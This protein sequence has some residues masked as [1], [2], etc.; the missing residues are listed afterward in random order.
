MCENPFKVHLPIMCNGHGHGQM[1][2]FMRDMV[3]IKRVRRPR[4]GDTRR[5][6][7]WAW[8]WGFRD[9]GTNKT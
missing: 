4:L 6:I 2:I 9:L 8:W 3:M 5:S 1:W 7:F